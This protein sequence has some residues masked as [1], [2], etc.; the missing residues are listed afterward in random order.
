MCRR[1]LFRF[2]TMRQRSAGSTEHGGCCFLQFQHASFAASKLAGCEVRG[3]PRLQS[4]ALQQI[5]AQSQ[6]E[7]AH[8]IAGWK[9]SAGVSKSAAAA[10][11]SAEESGPGRLTFNVG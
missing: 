8:I 1:N 9:P 7:F 10:T 6:L 11:A 2:E 5:S 4:I 3:I